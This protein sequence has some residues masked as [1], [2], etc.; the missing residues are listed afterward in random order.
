MSDRILVS[1]VVDDI[2]AHVKRGKIVPAEEPCES[3]G[4]VTRSPWTESWSVAPPMN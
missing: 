4:A 3:S 1:H 2:E